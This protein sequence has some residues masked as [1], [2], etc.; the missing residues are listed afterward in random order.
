MAASISRPVRD[1]IIAMHEAGHRFK[2]I[3]TELGLS[4]ATVAKYCKSADSEVEVA[5]SP[6]GLLE[7][8]EVFRLRQLVPAVTRGPCPGCGKPMVSLVTMVEGIC[9]HC[10]GEWTRRKQEPQGTPGGGHS[11]NHPLSGRP[12]RGSRVPPRGRY[13]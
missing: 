11:G 1:K 4:P 12:P 8:V 2:D 6:A 13:R 9:P 5:V 7:A 10:G 3:A